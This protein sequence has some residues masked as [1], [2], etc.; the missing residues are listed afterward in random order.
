MMVKPP[1]APVSGCRVS[2][3]EGHLLRIAASIA[4]GVSLNL[5]ACL[6]T[7]DHLAPRDWPAG[8]SVSSLCRGN[9]GPVQGRP[10]IRCLLFFVRLLVWDLPVGRYLS[11]R[12]NS[13]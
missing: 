8:P 13:R 12:S 1:S 10:H 5:G 9:V 4:E 7:L 3:S 11:F 6:S 2:D